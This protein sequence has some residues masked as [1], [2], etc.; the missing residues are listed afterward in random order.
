MSQCN[1]FNC[2]WFGGFLG[3][4]SKAII[5]FFT[6]KQGVMAER[7]GFEPWDPVKGQR[8]SRPPRSTTPAPLRGGLEVACNRLWLEGQGGFALFGLG[9]YLG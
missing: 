9:I 2:F 7:Q 1:A 5:E 8:F 4:V 6:Y 3:G